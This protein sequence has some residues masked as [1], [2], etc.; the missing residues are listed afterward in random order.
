MNNR[1]YR[2]RTDQMIGGVCGGLGRYLKIDANIIRL[3]FVLL[4]LGNGAGLILYLALWVILPYEGEGEAGASN[5]V[6]SGADEIAQRMRAM[7]EDVQHAFRQPNSKTGALVGGGL[8]ILG[9]IFLVDNLNLP[10]LRWLRFDVMWPV[11]II[12]L[13]AVMIWRQLR[14]S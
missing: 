3:L 2:S 8:I 5:T 1:L 7:G 9:L 11:L 14:K 12:A 13:G 10:W 6:H 4:G